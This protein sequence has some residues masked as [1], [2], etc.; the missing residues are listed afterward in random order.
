MGLV[1]GRGGGS[2][3]DGTFVVAEGIKEFPSGGKQESRPSME[4]GD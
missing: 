2:M 1:L 3:T 4:F